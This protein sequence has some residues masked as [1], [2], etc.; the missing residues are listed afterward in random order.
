VEGS[1]AEAVSRQVLERF[2]G[3]SLGA[4]ATAGL[5]DGVN[6]CAFTTIVFFI[7]MFAYLGKTRREMLAVGAAFAAGV[8]IAY[9]LL[10]IGLLTTVKSLAVNN[11]I[12]T[13]LAYAVAALAFILAAWSFRDFVMYRR[14]GD[15][16]SIT[17]ALPRPLKRRIHRVIRRGLSARSL[18]G[19]ALCVGFLVALLESLCTGQLYLPTIIFV[20]RAPG[21]KAGALGYL[22][23]YNVAFIT[24]L[25][26]ILALAWRG[27]TSR[28][29]G[30]FLRRH[31]G[32]LKLLTGVVF[33][34]L[35]LMVLGAG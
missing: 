9:F 31:L 35:A 1:Q 28:I 34:G 8:F 32:F 22:F 6:P 11:G 4:V 19:G 13:G 24:P 3:F 17:L 2:R 7:S 26:V 30:N 29:L 14:T 27:A 10:G 16:G 5:L 23:L 12:S 20:T 18:A 15:T 33:V 25:I 21:L